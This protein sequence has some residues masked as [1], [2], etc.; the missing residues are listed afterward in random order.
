MRPTISQLQQWDTNSI[1]RAAA[2]AGNA[3]FAL[4][5]SLDTVVRSMDDARLWFGATQRAASTRVTQEQ[6][7]AH[8]VRNVLQQI[9]D[10]AADACTDLAHMRDH[11]LGN[12]QIAEFLGYRVSDAGDVALPDGSTT[13]DTEQFAT[14]ISGGLD[15]LEKSDTAYGRQISDLASDLAAMVNGQPDVTIP[16]G[17]RLDPDQVVDMLRHLT[18]DQRRA[19]LRQM[20]PTDIRRV[21][22]ADPEAMGNMDGVGFEYRITANETNIRDALAN[23]IQAG[24]GTGRRADQLRKMLEQTADPYPTGTDGTSERQFLVFE[25]TANGRVVEMIGAL[26][27][28]TRN[29]TVYVPGTG[30]NLSGVA[31]PDRSNRKAAWN[32]AH[33][34]GGPVIVYMDGDLPQRIGHEHLLDSLRKGLGSSVAAVP[35]FGAGQALLHATAGLS[36]SA[37]DPHF[38]ADMAP[39][40]V[41]FGHELDVELAEHAPGAKTTYIGHSYG[42]SI[43]GTADQL[44]LRADNIIYASSAG[45]GLYDGNPTSPDTHRF[46]LTFPGD[47]IH[48]VQSLPGN[49]HGADP[50]SAPGITRLDTGTYE[51]DG[52]THDSGAR[53]HGDYWDDPN[54]TAFRNMVKVIT[55]QQ[56]DLYIYREP[57]TVTPQRLG[58]DV[59]NPVDKLLDVLNGRD[60]AYGLLSPEWSRLLRYSER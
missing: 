15:S 45:T 39:R 29:A 20:S 43:V 4:D 2:A 27:P 10:S 23:E 59:L 31:S 40:L 24:R 9:A 34:T 54:S 6:D 50:D 53:A 5:T 52:V 44:G 49:P 55:G 58:H 57:D 51:R 13:T 37:V 14:A 18:P 7:H 30:S 12:V 46:S 1:G 17:E 47:F 36:G 41:S 60:T 26:R 42:G 32:L 3:A 28:G 11:V 22:Q 56:P 33:Q 8:E 38:A 25:N 48:H 19:I 16:G 21:I 35:Q